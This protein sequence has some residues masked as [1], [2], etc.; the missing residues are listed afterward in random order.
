MGMILSMTG[1]GSADGLSGKTS[2]HAELKSVNNRF[3]DCSVRLPR[4]CSFAEETIKNLVQARVGR[5][6]VD[7]YIT[8][9]SSQED[10][11]T[12]TVNEPLLRAYK[13]AVD[14][15]GKKYLIP[16]DM[17]TAAYSRIPDIFVLEKKEL[18]QDLLLA[19][20]SRVM[21]GALDAFCAM[22][23][24][25]GQ[26]LAE[27]LLGKLDELETYRQKVAARSPET[28]KEYRERLLSKMQ[29]VLSAA[30]IDESR[31]LTE[32]ALYA[33]KVAVDEE[34]VRLDSHIRQFRDMLA[35]GGAVGRKLDFLIQEL[36]REVNTIGSKC[37]DLDITRMVVEMKS[38]IEKIREQAQNIE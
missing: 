19:D 34:L 9:D 18:D 10:D 26:R 23:E 16:N 25:E 37:A 36:N 27:D 7:V 3:L 5:G 28:V 38:I 8:V 2:L 29:E 15:M 30:G 13:Q 6:K 17:G 20:L 35:A 24:R 32:A 22:R 21:T 33:D 31:I 1:Y 11:V 4:S 12:V 14:D